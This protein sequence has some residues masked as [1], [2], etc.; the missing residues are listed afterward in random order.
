MTIQELLKPL[1]IN[2][3]AELARRTGISRW[4]AYRIWHG[5]R[6]GGIAARKIK[7][8]LGIPTDI[9]LSI[10]IKSDGG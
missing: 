7:E 8:R 9:L 4:W 1:G 5:Q 6:I 2:T 10:N 3:Y